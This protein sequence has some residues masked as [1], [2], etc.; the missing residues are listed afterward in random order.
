MKRP[1]QIFDISQSFNHRENQ[2]ML[3]SKFPYLSLSNG[4]LNF[5]VKTAA[6][7]VTDKTNLKRILNEDEDFR[8]S[9][10]SDE[11]VFRVLLDDE[12]ILLKISPVLFFEIL[13]AFIS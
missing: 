2:R 1:I 13:L 12:E 3:P 7:E 9:F 8:N 6:P 4:D 5:L 10:I 11:K